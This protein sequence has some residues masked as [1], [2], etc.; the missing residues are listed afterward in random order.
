MSN[1]KKD[2]LHKLE[3]LVS[4]EFIS[5]IRNT[6]KTEENDEKIQEFSH[7]FPETTKELKEKGIKKIEPTKHKY[8]NVTKVH[9]S[10]KR[11][12]EAVNPKELKTAFPET[13][14]KTKFPNKRIMLKQPSN[15]IPT[16]SIWDLVTREHPPQPEQET[17]AEEQ[18]P[19]QPPQTNRKVNKTTKQGLLQELEEVYD[20]G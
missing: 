6:K 9:D 10:I 4:D 15:D 18:E 2:N 11:E 14:G 17:A 8:P 12:Q 20:I 16:P 13:L 19:L 5:R 3:G 7:Q 1:E